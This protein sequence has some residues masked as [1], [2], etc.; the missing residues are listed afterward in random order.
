MPSKE[1][2]E[3]LHA[4]TGITRDAAHSKRIH[5]V[6]TWNSDDA[7][8]VRHDDMFVLSHDAKTGLLQSLDGIEVIDA[9]NLRHD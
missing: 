2:L 3:L 5:W 8:A 7:N 6:V 9:G 1:F 4:K